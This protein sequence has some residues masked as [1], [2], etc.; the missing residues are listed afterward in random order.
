M[1]RHKLVKALNLDE[2][3]DDFDGGAESD[4]EEEVSAE[5]KGIYPVLVLPKMR[6]W[7]PACQPCTDYEGLEHLRL[8][9][10]QVQDVLGPQESITVREIEDSLWHY[11]YDIDKTVNYLLST[12]Q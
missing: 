9:T 12:T 6:T 2:E 1:S 8:G 11:Y 7:M 5:D 3:L 4:Y 10:A